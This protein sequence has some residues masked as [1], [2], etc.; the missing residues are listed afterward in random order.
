MLRTR[1]VIKISAQTI[2]VWIHID[3]MGIWLAH[4]NEADLTPESPSKALSSSAPSPI[5]KKQSN[6]G[7][8][9][10]FGAAHLQQ[11]L[12]YS[13]KQSSN[14]DKD[15]PSA[16]YKKTLPNYHADEHKDI[17]KVIVFFLFFK[18]RISEVI[19]FLFSK[20]RISEFILFSKL[21][22]DYCLYE[23]QHCLAGS[24]NLS[25]AYCATEL[26][27]ASVIELPAPHL[28]FPPFALH[29]ST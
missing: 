2:W 8:T 4:S 19:F 6:A 16:P 29:T 20:L 26:F 13:P 24:H 14:D 9:C 18:L 23:S 1:G 17:S 28:L 5:T 3:W 12:D 25:I 22:T 21:C 15:W 7:E 10:H 27:F 11:L